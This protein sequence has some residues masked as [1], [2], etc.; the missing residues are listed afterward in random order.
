MEENNIVTTEDSKTQEWSQNQLVLEKISNSVSRIRAEIGKVIV[1]QDDMVTL[2]I[3]GL[4]AG[5]HLLIEGVPGIAKTLTAKL[6]AKTLSIDFSRD[7]KSTRL[8]SSHVA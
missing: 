1:G 7:R 8:N 5:G 3:T 6:L 2:L 4:F